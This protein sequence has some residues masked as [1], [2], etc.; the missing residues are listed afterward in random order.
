MNFWLNLHPLLRR[1][2]N[3]DYGYSLSDKDSELYKKLY[4]GEEFDYELVDKS[5]K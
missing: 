1:D 3:R 2:E 5:S 4:M